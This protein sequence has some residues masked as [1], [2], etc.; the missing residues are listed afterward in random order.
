[1][2]RK[3]VVYKSK[4]CVVCGSSFSPMSPFQKT[5]EGECRNKNRR[6]KERARNNGYTHIKSYC[7]MR[8]ANPFKPVYEVLGFELVGETKYT[9]HYFRGQNGI[10]INLYVKLPKSV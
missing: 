2:S 6:A 9:P 3:K 4:E 7:D 1:M 5:C 10:E 8:R